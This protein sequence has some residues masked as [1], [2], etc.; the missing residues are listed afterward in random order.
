MYP[1]YIYTVVRL[2]DKYGLPT[3]EIGELGW[4]PK[5]E[6]L[7]LLLEAKADNNIKVSHENSID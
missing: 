3:I 4:E 7:L 5:L 6:A 1:S 2:L